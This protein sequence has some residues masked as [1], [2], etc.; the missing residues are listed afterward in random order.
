[1][2]LTVNS[3]YTANTYKPTFKRV[4]IMKEV[5]RIP[6]VP[7]ACCGKEVIMEEAVKKVYSAVTKPLATMIKKGF[8]DRW[9]VFP[10]LWE[11]LNVFAQ[12]N[13]K[14]SLD[15]MLKKDEEFVLLKKAIVKDVTGDPNQ[16]TTNKEDKKKIIDIYTSVINDSRSELKTAKTV[17][18]KFGIFK[19]FLEGSRS[20]SFELFEIYSKK[21]PR[22]TLKDI[23]NDPAINK[24]HGLKNTLQKSIINL[25]REHYLGEIEDLIVKVSRSAKDEL[26]E[27]KENVTNLLL[28]E[29]DNNIK[30]YKIKD[31]YKKIL[32]KNN[33]TELEEKVNQTIEKIPL[34]YSSADLYFVSCVHHNYNDFEIINNIIGPYISS[35][36]H[37]IP[38]SANGEDAIGNGLTLHTKCNKHRG[39][40]PYKELLE[41]HPEMIE[42]TKKQIDYISNALLT[43]KAHDYLRYWP[44]KVTKTLN[45]YTDGKISHDVSEYCQKRL[46]QLQ[47]KLK[48]KPPE[49]NTDES[50]QISVFTRYLEGKWNES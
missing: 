50:R 19:T 14:E 6:G 1:M 34:T 39:K 25:K 24:T 11:A 16:T 38:R 33:C 36:E 40:I 49:P 48:G 46:K 43:G 23:V 32:T 2:N 3:N 9:K 37:I 44:L 20:E 27:S 47:R 13:P 18:S 22:K 26:E 7:C 5:K 30:L 41:Y 8:M 12:V 31:I 4:D 15:K 42:N 10:M 45:K 21:H 35:Y 28:R 29:R 17:I